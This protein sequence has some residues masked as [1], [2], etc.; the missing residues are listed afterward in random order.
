MKNNSTK[1]CHTI[2]EVI[3]TTFLK[4]YENDQSLRE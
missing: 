4:S 1:I 3:D 2:S